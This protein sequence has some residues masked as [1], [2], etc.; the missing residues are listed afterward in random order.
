MTNTR[1]NIKVYPIILT[2]LLFISTAINAEIVVSP[3][4]PSTGTNVSVKLITRSG[5]SASILETSIT[6]VNNT[7]EIIQTIGTICMLPS[8]P[9][10]ESNFNLGLLEA[11]DYQITVTNNHTEVGG[12]ACDDFVTTDN[13]TFQVL[14]NAT[15]IPLGGSYWMVLLLL[16]M[17][18]LG[19]YYTQANRV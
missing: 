18:A 5:S 2:L 15:V 19:M 4:T 11:G 14:G 1:K 17:A 16:L 13:S 10:L 6:R 12:G 8:A 9:I 7:F 3:H